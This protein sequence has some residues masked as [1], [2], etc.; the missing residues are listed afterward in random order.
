M[1]L[2]L[3][4]EGYLRTSSEEFALDDFNP[5]V[6]LTNNAVQINNAKYGLF[7]P[8]NHLSFRQLETLLREVGLALEPIL[9]EIRAATRTVFNSARKE[10]NPNH[11]KFTF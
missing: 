10:L 1:G 2:Y 5:F 11:R 8:G 7:E 4:R 3:F 9:A 6:H